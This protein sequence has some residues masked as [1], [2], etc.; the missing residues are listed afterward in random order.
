MASSLCN[1]FWTH[2]NASLQFTYYILSM[3]EHQ[4]HHHEHGHQRSHY[5]HPWSFLKQLENMGDEYL[6]R[7]A[8]WPLPHNRKV[9][10]SKVLPVLA[11]I[12]AIISIPH[13]IS[14]TLYLLGLGGRFV[15]GYDRSYIMVLIQTL[16]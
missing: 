15:G 12:I 13:I 16:I 9:A 2:D 7:K 8:P 3:H 11:L 5:T 1:V 6:V 10:I 4:S 14:S